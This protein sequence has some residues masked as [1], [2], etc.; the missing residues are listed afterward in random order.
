MLV[1]G[2]RN[3]IFV[4][5]IVLLLATSSEIP[6][7]HVFKCVDANGHVTY[8]QTYSQAKCEGKKSEDWLQQIPGSGIQPPPA[9]SSLSDSTENGNGRDSQELSDE[10]NRINQAVDEDIQEI[11]NTGANFSST[12]KVIAEMEVN[13]LQQI[14]SL[15]IHTE[16][17]KQVIIENINRSANKAIDRMNSATKG[18]TQLRVKAVSLIQMS[19]T[20]LITTVN[21]L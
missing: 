5:T 19:Q 16:S 21:N 18:H 11:T 4:A 6:A 9:D 8:S 10:I 17:D 20:R 1:A 12:H 13:R 14:A 3:G 2:S 7:Q 15:P